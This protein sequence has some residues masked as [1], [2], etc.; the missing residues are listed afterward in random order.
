M[1]R[2]AVAAL[3]LVLAAASARSEDEGPIA[4]ADLEAL[5]ERALAA[6]VTSSGKST[7][8]LEDAAVQSEGGVKADAVVAALR[9]GAGKPGVKLVKHSENLEVPMLR[10]RLSALVVST[11]KEATTDFGLY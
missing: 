9:A 10:V 6:A 5:A 3:V 1:K 4:K 2:V 7:Y 8:A 11:A